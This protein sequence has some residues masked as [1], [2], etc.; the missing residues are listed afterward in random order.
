VARFEEVST[1]EYVIQESD[2]YLD[3]LS[4]VKKENLDENG[5]IERLSNIPI[6]T[7]EEVERRTI[8]QNENALW[9]TGRQFRITSSNFQQIFK[10]QKENVD[11]LLVQFSNKTK[12]IETPAL[13]WGRKR[14][15]I[16]RKTY[17]A[18]K[19]LKHNESVKVRECG[20]FLCEKSGY[21]GASPDGIV[22]SKIDT[23]RPWVL[24][25]KCPYKWRFKTIRDACRDRNFFVKLIVKM[26]Y[27]EK[28]HTN[29]TPK[30]KDNWQ[31]VKL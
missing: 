6:P 8:V 26:K 9:K 24:E 21:L 4:I 25:I 15:S 27:S 16:A 31:S 14:E 28:S 2:K 12:S 7:L 20:L 11:K 10:R 30:S 3:L 13:Q 1:S 17:V 23:C 18:Y 22:T 5:I 29:I 19:K